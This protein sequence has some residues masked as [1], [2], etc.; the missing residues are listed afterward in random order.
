MEKRPRAVTPTLL[1]IITLLAMSAVFAGGVA[2][3]QGALAG[4]SV[5][6]TQ[7]NPISLPTTT[8]PSKA[9]RYPLPITVPN[10]TTGTVTGVSV[11]L[12]GLSHTAAFD[13]DIL[14][15]GPTGRSALLM[16]DA[17][18]T[19]DLNDATLTF[20][21]TATT[22]LPETTAIANGTYQ[23]T[24]YGTGDIF[25]SPAPGPPK[26]GYGTSLSTFN[27][28]ARGGVWSLYIV[29]DLPTAFAGDLAGGWELRL[30]VSLGGS[31]ATL[32]FAT[33]SPSLIQN[34]RTGSPYPSR[35][36][37]S[38][39]TG[40]IETLH[41]ALS[42]T[43]ANPDDLDVL[44]VS[45]TGTGIMLMSDVGGSTDVSPV[46]ITFDH[47]AASGVPDSGPL[48]QGRF[49]PTDIDTGADD[50]VVSPA[51]E[52]RNGQ[53][54]DLRAT[55]PNGVW[56]LYVLDDRP[57]HDAGTIN[58]WSIEIETNIPPTPS[59]LLPTEIV[60]DAGSV[61][62]VELRASD[63]DTL[64]RS[65]TW[66]AGNLPPWAS[67]V[68]PEEPDFGDPYLLRIAPTA[69]HIG[70]NERAAVMVSDGVSQ[71][72]FDFQ[73][74]V[75]DDLV[76][77]TVELVQLE[78][79]NE[80]GWQQIRPRVQVTG[81]DDPGGTGV[82]SIIYSLAGALNRDFEE[83]ESD[84]F[85]NHTYIEGIITMT[86]FA[87]DHA[88]NAGPISTI[89]TK[90]DKTAPT[91]GTVGIRFPEQGGLSSTL[92]GTT[93]FVP[94][95]GRWSATDATSGVSQY[96]A[97]IEANGTDRTAIRLTQPLQPRATLQLEPGHTY[98]FAAGAIDLAD[99]QSAE[100]L[101]PARELALQDDSD[102]ASDYSTGWVT[103]TNGTFL[104]GTAH[105]SI[106]TDSTVT[107]TFT[108]RS[109]TWLTSFG[110]NRGIA[111][112]SI[113]GGAPVLVDTYRSFTKHRQIAFAANNLTDTQH[114]LVIR[115]TGNKNSASTAA[116]IF[117]DGFATLR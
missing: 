37:V 115:V 69:S 109:V 57:T 106:T 42:I 110:P 67:V 97:A 76:A 31:S 46:V 45:P 2:R 40:N 65:L 59:Q 99:N 114:T 108:G 9:D 49:R 52:H 29:D 26:G 56:S 15:V 113:D 34:V 17:G 3:P 50:A 6:F 54:T 101:S 8:A 92:D 66:S 104:G 107:Y 70:F 71:V 83:I 89:T 53:L 41:V 88:G 27:D 28:V 12:H 105:S 117:I 19:S 13:L 58:S 94:V 14:L 80:D 5:T 102:A 43:H 35:I 87:R 11:T 63:P 33:D 103:N 23:P 111:E 55:D 72:E 60:A 16:S 64:F 51:P 73:L 61:R 112:V 7:P 24:N 32:I 39:M 74:T 4:D 75:V 82:A 93:I 95:Q 44:L 68:S 48:T 96:V 90:Y 18:R 21:S 100:R 30:R 91:M 10:S 47:D 1:V 81:I 36:T 22:P 78:P 85:F 38:G 98:R 116:R 20:S 86:V 62:E 84:G 79:M 77:P 25:P